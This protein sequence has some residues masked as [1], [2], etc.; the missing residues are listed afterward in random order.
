[1]LGQT[2]SHGIESN[3]TMERCGLTLV[4][5]SQSEEVNIHNLATAWN[6]PLKTGQ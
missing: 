3:I 6:V 5:D 2:L 4:F 1:M